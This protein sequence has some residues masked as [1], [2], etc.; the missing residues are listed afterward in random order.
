MLV[1]G[2]TD[3]EKSRLVLECTLRQVPQLPV[4]LVYRE[5]GT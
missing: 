4:L 3:L 5:S 1:L 2:S